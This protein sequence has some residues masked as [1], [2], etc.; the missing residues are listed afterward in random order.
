MNGPF[1]FIVDA[2]AEGGAK[3]LWPFFEDRLKKAGVEHRWRATES[4]AD[5]ARLCDKIGEEW[6]P[7]A[8]GGD[9]ALQALV[10]AVAPGRTIAH[11]PT[12]ADS[13][14]ARSVGISRAPAKAL[15]QL[16]HGRARPIDLPTANG[17]PFLGVAGL[18][19]GGLAG[20]FGL[21]TAERR[22]SA[23]A[24]LIS[25]IR[26]SAR[27]REIVITVDGRTQTGKTL[28]VAIGNC[29][30]FGGLDVCPLAHPDDGLL[31][32][33]LTDELSAKESLVALGRLRR[34]THVR[35]PK[36]HYTKAHQIA[37]DGPPGTSVI[38]D[39]RALTMLP[40][41]VCVQQQAIKVI[42]P[43]E[44]WNPSKVTSILRRRSG[45]L[46]NGAQ[47]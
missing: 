1:Y 22:R 4:P 9:R 21:P 35:H 14:F 30:Y 20:L 18:A 3:R 27:Q 8:V 19:F 12:G 2:G 24:A 28:M 11:V 26:P 42:V 7:V 33:C 5:V 6:I 29:R 31:D 16:L 47:G 13:D 43:Q 37:I 17:R 40:V 46:D 15:Y 39:G 34:G 32:L 38:A 44:S 41:A 25:A 10:E 45:P 23:F 36:V